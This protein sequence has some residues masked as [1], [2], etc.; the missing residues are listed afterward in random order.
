MWTLPLHSIVTLIWISCNISSQYT[1]F[2]ILRSHCDKSKGEVWTSFSLWCTWRYQVRE[3]QDLF[4]F[5]NFRLCS[6][7]FS[8]FFLLFCI[9]C[10]RFFTYIDSSLLLVIHQADIR[11][12][13]WKRW[14]SSW[15]GIAIFLLLPSVLTGSNLL[16]ILFEEIWL[17]DIEILPSFILNQ[18]Y[19][20]V[21]YSRLYSGA[22]T[23]ATNTFSLLVGGRSTILR[24]SGIATLY[25]DL[26]SLKK[27]GNKTL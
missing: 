13:C 5:L 6:N 20:Y 8:V 11:C 22:G 4:S 7:I 14:E 17:H 25:T 2:H 15:E 26:K 1:A 18:P 21:T 23:N 27:N 10:F 3:V 12:D 9:Y 16:F 24:L 19:R